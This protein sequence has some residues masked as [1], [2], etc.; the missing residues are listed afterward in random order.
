MRVIDA[1]ELKLG[2]ARHGSGA[3]GNAML[4]NLSAASFMA[5]CTFQEYVA[6]FPPG[7]AS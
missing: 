4:L 5:Y 7:L 6:H 1:T 3:F 2:C